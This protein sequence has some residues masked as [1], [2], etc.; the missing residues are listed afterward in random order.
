[1][2]SSMVKRRTSPQ[3]NSTVAGAGVLKSLAGRI[4]FSPGEG[5]VNSLHQCAE[6]VTEGMPTDVLHLRGLHSPGNSRASVRH[7]LSAPHRRE[8]LNV[9]R[10]FSE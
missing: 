8:T 2:F 7:S 4:F 10:I 3:R 6:R 5:I 1:M 9:D